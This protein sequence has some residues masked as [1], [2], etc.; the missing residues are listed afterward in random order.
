MTLRRRLEDDPIVLDHGVP[1]AVRD[2]R[3][4]LANQTEPAE[5]YA[6]LS[7]RCVD[8]LEFLSPWRPFVTRVLLRTD[9]SRLDRSRYLGTTQGQSEPSQIIHGPSGFITPYAIPR[10]PGN[11]TVPGD[12]TWNTNPATATPN[13]LLSQTSV[14]SEELSGA[15]AF[16][17]VEA[18]APLVQKTPIRPD[19]WIVDWMVESVK[20]QENVELVSGAA[21]TADPWRGILNVAGISTFAAGASPYIADILK[22]IAKGRTARRPP[23]VAFVSTGLAHI[24]QSARAAGG[25]PLLDPAPP[26]QMWPAGML[27]MDPRLIVGWLRNVPI[28]ELDSL[29]NGAAATA[30]LVGDFSQVVVTQR[31]QPNGMLARLDESAHMDFASDKYRY[32]LAESFD[33]T[34]TPNQQTSIYSITAVNAPAP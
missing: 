16:D 30:A 1:I 8:R 23:N 2:N 33:V 32:R 18:G 14:S 10:G 19:P 20:T 17:R 12:V 6:L 21:S 5:G 34:M 11:P 25:G 28:V 15:I 29:A 27:G 4:D 13:E 26:V 24:I 9:V 7:R 3:D 31:V 22:A